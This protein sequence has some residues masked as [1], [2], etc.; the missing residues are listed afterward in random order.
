MRLNKGLSHL[1]RFT[2]R[3]RYAFCKKPEKDNKPVEEK[4]QNKFVK[5]LKDGWRQTFPKDEDEVRRK[6]QKVK[7]VKRYTEE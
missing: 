6:Y 5:F 7:N 1:I 2:M 3:N 4:S